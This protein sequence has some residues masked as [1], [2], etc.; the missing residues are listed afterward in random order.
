MQ[1]ASERLA[2]LLELNVPEAQAQDLVKS[3]IGAGELEDDLETAATVDVTK[4]EK[5]LS[6]LRKSQ[7]STEGE[8]LAK[9]TITD[10]RDDLPS[11]EIK[12]M[13]D[14]V[15]TA[16]DV[17]AEKLSKALVHVGEM[18]AELSTALASIDRRQGELAKSMSESAPAPAPKSVTGALAAVPSPLDSA[19]R[20][21]AFEEVIT[22]RKSAV[23]AIKGELEKDGNSSQRVDALTS[24]LREV[25]FSPNPRAVAQRAGITL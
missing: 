13:L 16:T 25:A 17:Q 18:V 8:K 9:S 24:A 12:R 21:A 2:K 5:I 3:A 11:K 19:D 6:E 7:E 1:K 4:L 15:V 23:D 22:L 10:V 14:A 20:T